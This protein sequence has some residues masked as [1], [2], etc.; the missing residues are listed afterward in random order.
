M[1][2]LHYFRLKIETS[3]PKREVDPIFEISYVNN[4]WMYDVLFL[5]WSN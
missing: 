1:I 2:N 5:T 3:R 4:V